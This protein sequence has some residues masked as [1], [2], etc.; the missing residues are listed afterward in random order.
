[1]AYYPQMSSGCSDIKNTLTCITNPL[2]GDAAESTGTLCP[3]PT[4]LKNRV[5]FSATQLL[6]GFLSHSVCH[7]CLLQDA[8]NSGAWRSTFTSCFSCTTNFDTS[9]WF[10]SMHRT[11]FPGL[12]VCVCWF[13]AAHGCTSYSPCHCALLC[14][15]VSLFK[16]TLKAML[17]T[18]GEQEETEG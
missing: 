16:F 18:T 4:P 5:T 15:R 2:V 6:L 9:R 11:F 13:G 7:G 3:V 10:V 14:F 8:L 1:M 12:S 17:V